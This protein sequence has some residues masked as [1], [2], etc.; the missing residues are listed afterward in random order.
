I[1]TAVTGSGNS[2]YYFKVEAVEGGYLLRLQTPAGEPYNI[3]GSPGYLNSGADGGFDGCFILGLN[4]QNGQDVENG[5]VWEIEYDADKGFALKNKARGGYFAGPNPAPTATEPI[6]WTFCTLKE[7]EEAPDP[8]PVV[9]PE[10]EAPLAEGE[11]IPDFFSICDEGGIPYG[12]DVK[13]GSEDRAYP[14]TFGGGARIF[15]FAEGG[16][17]TKAIYYREGYVQYGNV[18]KLALEAGK[19]YIVYFNSAMWKDSGATL[20][21]TI[22]KEGEETALMDSVISNTPNVNGSKNAVTG[23][24]RS[25]IE[26]TPEADGNYI[27]KWD[28]EGWK[29]VLLANVGVKVAPAVTPT[30]TDEPTIIDWIAGDQGYE[31]AI[32][33]DGVAIDLDAKTTMTCAKGTGSTTPK[34]YITGSAVRTYGGN[35]ITFKGEGITKIIITGVSGKVAELTASTGELTTEGIVTT[36]KGEADEI[37]LTN[38]TKNQQ[39]IVKLHVVYGGV[40]ADIEPVHIANTAETAYTVAKAIELIDAGDA[41]DE[42]VFVKGIVSQVEGFNDTYKNITYSIS[43]DGT[44][45]SAQFKCYRGKGINGADFTSVDDIEVGAEVVVTGTMTKYGEIYEFN[46]DNALVSYKA[47]FKAPIA[48]GK[49]YLYNVG[50]EGFIVGANDWGT[51]ASIAKV[52]GVE[53]EAVMADGKYELKTASLYPGK[54]IGFNGYVDNGDA[55]NWTIVP[56]EGQEGVFTLSTDGT[57]VLFWDGGEATTTT[58]GAMPETAANAHWKFISAEDRLASL[59]SAT[60]E[61]PVDAT[62][63]IQNPNF[64][65]AASTAAWTMEASNKNLSGGANENMCAESYHA[66]FTLSQTLANAPAGKYK[67]TAQGFYRQ[68]GEDNENLPVFYAND[69]TGTFPLK[70]GSENSMT[71]ASA[72]FTAGQYTI[73]PIEVTVFEDGQLTIG[74]KLI[75]NTNLWCI[76]DNFVLSYVSKDIPADE[77]APAY[78]AALEAAQAALVNEAYAAVTG[79]EKTALEK[80][81]S[82]FATIPNTTDSVKLAI[83]TL[84]A[85]TTTFTTAKAAYEGLTAA[86]AEKA[87]LSFAYATAEKKAAAEAT[88]TAEATS[89]A[90]ATAKT[91]AITKAYRQYAESSALLEGVEGAQNMTDAILNPQAENEVN[92]WTTVLGEGSGGSIGIRDNEPWTDGADNATHKYFDGGNWGAQAWDVTLEQKSALPKGKYQLTVKSRAAGDVAFTLFAGNDSTA[93]PAI[94]GA[95]GLFNR[96]WND[97]SVE[98]ELTEADS[99]AIGVRG[100]TTKQYNWMSFSDFRLIQ[101]PAEV[102]IAHTWDFTKWSDAT[103][104]NLKAEA[105]KGYTEG[106]WSDS[107]KADGSASTMEISKDNCFWQVGASAA[108]GET[109]TANGEE[110]AELKGLIFKNNKARSLAIAVNYGDCTSANGEGFGPYHGGAY[111]W[112]GSKNIEYFTIPAVKGGTTITMGV[113]SHKITDA[114]GVKLFAGETE[115]MGTDGNAVAAPTTYT[116]QTWTVPA[117]VAYDIVVKNTNGC[118]IYFIDAEQDQEVLTSI[119]T[120]K[121]NKQLNDTIF[122]LNGQKVNKAQKGLYIINGRKVVIK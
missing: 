116:E 121:T 84:S 74:A 23:S 33:L 70:T 82:D 60:A 66:V 87:T 85:A 88:L 13:F 93:M 52:G 86:K 44:A 18:K 119:S 105:A 56:V 45:E 21:F 80:A 91:E 47:P 118:H 90:D 114:R 81:I 22:T 71:D 29:E 50:A 38:S 27:L 5:A 26:F 102:E 19:K 72:S 89:A 59:A 103:V 75:T 1:T 31:N 55:S 73:E 32:E 79:E 65:R 76:F 61:N 115:L 97:A 54:H 41:L 36:W 120:V 7:G 42:T 43:D 122:N 9:I 77:F 8:E 37:V 16:D 20:K 113:E 58:V 69:K 108:E 99:I 62:F 28:A 63:L 12:Y 25:E 17:F 100:V 30:P 104:A 110:I 96:G 15:N 3:W 2:G 11:L 53:I 107:E 94:G 35:T 92:N 67:M 4:N 101:F 98:F 64:S 57:N 112:L 39:H 10:P 34:Y 48:D 51:R 40:E 24:T 78:A 49:Y 68:D 95:N 111:L 109:L 46:Q 14:A 6:Y 83:S 106:L 117:G